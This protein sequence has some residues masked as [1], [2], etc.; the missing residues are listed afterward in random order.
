MSESFTID[1]AVAELTADAPPEAATEDPAPDLDNAALEGDNLPADDPA[2]TDE[3]AETPA[4]DDTGDVEAPA[5]PVAEAPSFWSAEGKAVF[6]TLT[7]EAQA[8][9]L[10]EESAVQKLTAKKLEGTAAERKAAKAEKERFASLA[11]RMSEAAHKAESTFASR[12]DGISQE[13]WAALAKSDPNSYTA[14]RAQFDLESQTTQQA[15]AA[16]DDAEKARHTEWLQEQTEA[17]KT[18]APA[19]VDPVKGAENLRELSSYLVA[20]GV[21]ED[22]LPHV[23]ARSM[24][25]AR[26]AMLYDTGV[27]KLAQPARPAPSRPALKP[28]GADGATSSQR[29]SA[30]AMQRLNNSGSIDD[31]VAVLLARK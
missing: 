6:A 30:S 10:A 11:E 7:P 23:D 4:E 18:L 20:Q 25:I 8:A 24:A 5:E 29:T 28:S 13:A 16:R 1:Q 21:P 15:K 31:A 26:K 19:L 9:I 14:L 3:A 17:L 2:A 22:A 12:W 27:A